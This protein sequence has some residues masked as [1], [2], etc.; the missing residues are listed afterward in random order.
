MEDISSYLF[1]ALGLGGASVLAGLLAGFL[2]V[3][4][5]IVLVPVL[6]WL[7]TFID[8]P[9][10]L[11]MHMA[12]A[13]SLGTIVFTAISSTR[14]HHERGAVDL[15]LLKAWGV[16]IAVG[17]LTGGLMARFIDPAGLKA[18]FGFV[19][20]AVA[21][22]LATPKTFVISDRLPEGRAKNASIA[23]AI[24]LVSS[25]MGIG[26]GTLGVPTLAAFSYPIHRAVGTAA[27]FGLI[28]AVPA[29]IGFVI[30]GLGVADRPPL[31]LGYVSLPAVLIIIPFT[32]FMAP[33]GARLAH[34]LD[35]IWVK[36]GFAVFLAIT[37]VR[38]LSSV[39][40]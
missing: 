24:G 32:T 9:D 15:D 12:V 22:N 2:G 13:T 23:G 1:L 7:F 18:I 21:V 37:S 35:A 38:M 16:P 34:D 17:A 25:L 6:F 8:F 27:A 14:A 29:V 40:G 33:I 31:S 39:F 4:G 28:I 3:G 5:G 36:R 20:L 11:S 10:T 26:G 30:S 19:A